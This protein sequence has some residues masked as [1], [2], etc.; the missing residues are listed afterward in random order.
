MVEPVFS[1]INRLIRSIIKDARKFSK[2]SVLH[3]SLYFSQVLQL[4]Q[5]QTIL[6][7]T[8]C[9]TTSAKPTLTS[10][11]S[12]TSRLA[13]RPMWPALTEPGCQF[14]TPRQLTRLVSGTDIM[15]ELITR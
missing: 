6:N 10:M 15:L 2:I 9:T 3:F 14:R 5:D 8:S 11:T 13:P 7:L 1:Y 4:L 12:V